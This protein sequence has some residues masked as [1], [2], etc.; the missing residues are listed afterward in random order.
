VFVF[1][2]TLHC[3]DPLL[4]LRPLFRLSVTSVSC[5]HTA[6][7]LQNLYSLVGKGCG[8]LV[9]R[10]RKYLQWFSRG[11]LCTVGIK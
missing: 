3:N 9:K 7:S 8:S 2:R 1:S 11:L 4:N 5:D 10:S 6:V